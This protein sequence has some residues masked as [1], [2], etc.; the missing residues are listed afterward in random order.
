[1]LGAVCGKY[2]LAGQ[3]DHKPTVGLQCLDGAEDSAN[4]CI[5][6]NVVVWNGSLYLIHDSSAEAATLSRLR[7]AGWGPA[8][9][10]NI[11]DYFTSGDQALLVLYSSLY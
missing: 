3:S 4:L 2:A 11:S 9:S 5:V 10:F 6:R 1:M 7:L 8:D